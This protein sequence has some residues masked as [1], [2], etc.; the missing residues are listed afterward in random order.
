MKDVTRKSRTALLAEAETAQ[1]AFARAV[2]ALQAQQIAYID[3]APDLAP[4]LLNECRVQP[5]RAALLAALPKGGTIA[6]IGAGDPERSR[7]LVQALQPETLYRFVP[8]SA[9]P[10]DPEAPAA[11]GAVHVGDAIENLARVPKDRFDLVY[12]E[13]AVAYEDAL[14]T[15]VAVEP[16]LKPGGRLV[17]TD[18]T[19]WSVSSMTRSGVARAVNE[20]ANSRRWGV[21]AIALQSAGYYDLCLRR[22]A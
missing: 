4:E 14:R 6:E 12:L 2:R 19:A 9:A 22:P 18:Y 8:A 5:N 15:L 20:F 11:I 1:R 21:D 17:V 3:R 10:I 7:Q 13:C 16:R